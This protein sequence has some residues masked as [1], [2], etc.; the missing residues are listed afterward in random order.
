MI[1][2]KL[3]F[4]SIAVFSVFLSNQVIAAPTEPIP[5]AVQ[6]YA[7][8]FKVTD[9]EARRRLLIQSNLNKLVDKI[10][11]KYKG[12]IA[13]IYFDN[14]NEF[15]LVVRI[16][17]KGKDTKTNWKLKGGL[18]NGITIPIEVKKNSQY[19]FND[20]QE[21]INSKDIQLQVSR[22]VR[23][24]QTL[25]YN[26]KE[27]K[28]EIDVYDNNLNKR[29]SVS[30]VLN[31]Q[32]A[33]GIPFIINYLSEPITTQA[34]EVA[35]GG[36]LFRKGNESSNCTA[37]FTGTRNGQLGVI[38]AAHCMASGV[39]DRYGDSLGIKFNILGNYTNY[40]IDHDIAFFPIST[41]KIENKVYLMRV[42]DIYRAPLRIT[43]TGIAK[44]S[45]GYQTEYVAG[46]RLCHFG[47]TTGYSCGNVESIVAGV[48]SNGPGCS[49]QLKNI[50]AYCAT[51]NVK[52]IGPELKAA[53]GDS[54][55]PWF[56][57]SGK[58]YGIHSAGGQN[59]LSVFS[60]IRYAV[61]QLGFT[62]K[63]S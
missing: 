59:R 8:E 49:A 24:I 53:S 43:G 22:S 40:S 12:K 61:N 4:I 33:L 6:S 31:L 21:I 56:D 29:S 37:G 27:D 57:T 42:S 51:N 28:I 62:L 16:T 17:N 2:T 34:G 54:G 44:L 30:S 23:G 58:A 11:V 32:N 63:T 36:D 47:Q 20:I 39:V 18:V 13:G 45:N 60:P 52:V 48:G 50:N 7:K 14:G 35:G 9:L 19:N 41:T 25:G 15:K 3:K 46:N 26:P 1:N 10:N 5:S 38:T 55:G